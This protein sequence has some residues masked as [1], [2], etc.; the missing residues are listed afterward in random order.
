MYEACFL[1]LTAVVYAESI[2]H[3][4]IIDKHKTE[5]CFLRGLPVCLPSSPSDQDISRQHFNTCV[6]ASEV[7]F[8]H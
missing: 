6:D 7:T 8:K 1:G 5:D 2:T 4:V 3:Q